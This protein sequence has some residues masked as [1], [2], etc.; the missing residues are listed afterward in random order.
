M[1][2]GAPPQWR[3]RDCRFDHL[4]VAALNQGLSKVLVYN[5]IETEERAHDVRR[6]IYRCARHRGM[7]A[8]AG[9]STLASGD[10]MG[11]HKMPDGTFTLKYRLFDKRQ[12]RK[13]HLER[14]GADRQQWPYNPRRAASAGE[15]ESWA[16]RDE[17]GK[18]VR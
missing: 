9:P 2:K 17:K 5:G 10:A 7:S 18:A 12:A 1:P 11:V 4:V 16:S 13:R 14:Y 3:K 8:D 6:G 15:R